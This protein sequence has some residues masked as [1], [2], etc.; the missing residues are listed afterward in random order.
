MAENIG[1]Y[2]ILARIGRGGMGTIFKAHDPVLDRTVALKII[3]S[4]LE[5]TAELRARFFREAQACARLSHPNIVTVHDMGEDSGRLFIV[6]E[7]LEGKE[8]RHLIAEGAALPLEDKLSIMGQ[9]CDGIH[10]AHQRGIIHRDIKPGNIMLLPSGQVKILDFGVARIATSE[11]EQDLTRTGLVMGTLRYIA[12]EQMQGRVDHRSDIFS[13][14]AVF[15]ELLNGQP[16][17]TGTNA[18]QILEQIRIHDPPSLTDLNPSV[19]SEL[20]ALIDRA[21][22]KVPDERFPDL[23]QMRAQIGQVQRQLEEE[24]GGS[25]LVCSGIAMIWLGFNGNWPIGSGKPAETPAEP[26]PDERARTTVLQSLERDLVARVD[27][28]RAEVARADALTAALQTAT[29]LLRAGRA[30]EAVSTP[31]ADHRGHAAACDSARSARSGPH[32]GRG[33]AAPA[34]GDR[35]AAGSSCRARRRCVRPV[36]RSS[37]A[38]GRAFLAGPDTT[39]MIASLRGTAE[40]GRAAHE[41]ARQR[42]EQARD[43][44]MKA[45]RMAQ[46]WAAPQHAPVIWTDAEAQYAEGQSAFERAAYEEA[47]RAFDRGTE[48]YR[49]AEERIHEAVRAFEIAPPAMEPPDVPVPPIEDVGP[50]TLTDQTIGGAPPAI[51]A[52][53]S[54]NATTLFD[55]AQD[56]ATGTMPARRE[57]ETPSAG[58]S[59]KEAVASSQNPHRESTTGTRRRWLLVASGPVVA[60]VGAAAIVL[61]V[62]TWLPHISPPK[63]PSGPTGTTPAATGPAS[64]VPSPTPSSAKQSSADLPKKIAPVPAE[65]KEV[66]TQPGRGDQT[67]KDARNKVADTAITV[68]R[69]LD[70]AQQMRSA[71]IGARGEAEKSAAPRLASQAFSAARQQEVEGE[72]ALRRQDAATAK[73]LFREAQ[74]GYTE[75]AQR[76]ERAAAADQERVTVVQRQQAETERTRELTAGARRA[77]EQAGAG[78]YAQKLLASAQA[79]ERDAEGALGRSDYGTAS[80]LFG[81]ARS[82]YRAAAQEAERQGAAIKAT[83]DQSRRTA[84]ALREDALK[85]E[86]D[87]L[88][89]VVF[90]AGSSKADRGRGT[91]QPSGPRGGDAG[92]YRG[93]RAVRGSIATCEGDSREQSS[94]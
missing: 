39:A 80:R 78:R 81:E 33:R 93:G 4:D 2:R 43:R 26:I 49:Q 86:A 12:P 71:A 7:L 17:F 91:W 19:P 13:V 23:A 24:S 63:T 76:A 10:Y 16:P 52:A 50:A 37:G 20:S 48:L 31:R 57:V 38:G 18:L 59:G 69:G 40:A 55:R 41:S 85:T 68:R 61:G 27:A 58:G 36:L 54:A 60:L 45:R 44:M 90:D 73:P 32:R 21:M 74:R 22:R 66:A 88:A 94:S 72:A 28:L 51:S 82:D 3:S 56:R 89:K 35:A 8:L 14:G 75:A 30:T 92:I 77:A 5:V 15:Y 67:D 11:S 62:V 1:K 79:K 65:Q 70:E 29:E 25:G 6:M 53:V 47:V 34:S 64:P 46:A 83:T 42:I 87:R 9:V 84:L